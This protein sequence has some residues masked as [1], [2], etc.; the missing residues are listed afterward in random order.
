MTD[1]I[2]NDDEKSREKVNE[3]DPDSQG[4]SKES[5]HTVGMFSSLRKEPEDFND[6]EF[7]R[8][9]GED[10]DLTPEER[11]ERRR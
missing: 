9:L 5:K 1:S 3:P 10:V 8:L 7:E 4:K 2:N 11:K 6:D